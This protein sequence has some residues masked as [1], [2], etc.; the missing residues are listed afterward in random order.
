MALIVWS[1]M[2]WVGETGVFLSAAFAV[3][4][5]TEPIA[6]FLAMPIGT[7]STLLPSSPGYIGTFDYFVIEAATVVGNP[8][9]AA[10]AFA[11]VAHLILWTTATVVGGICF[12][13][14]SF[15]RITHE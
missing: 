2:A 8:P 5:M 7:L 9:V 10:S 3:P 14:W 12:A 4:S 13:I 11:V 6:A 15:L 1:I